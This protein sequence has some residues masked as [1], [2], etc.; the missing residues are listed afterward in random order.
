MESAIS[1]H[2]IR[3]FQL[4]K[5]GNRSVG[6]KRCPDCNESNTPDTRF[7][8]NCGRSYLSPKHIPRPL[9]P[10]DCR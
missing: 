8:T 6:M 10:C 9:S 5:V 7:C 4:P 2:G 3:R 1:W